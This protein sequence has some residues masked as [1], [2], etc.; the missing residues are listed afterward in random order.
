MIMYDVFQNVVFYK[1]FVVN[2]QFIIDYMMMFVVGGINYISVIIYYNLY[3]MYTIV[4]AQSII[5]TLYFTTC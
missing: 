1:Q 5:C 3:K 2:A 4:N